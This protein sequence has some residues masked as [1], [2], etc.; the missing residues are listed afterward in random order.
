M[1]KVG[2]ISDT[3]GMLRRAAL[4]AL[5]GCEQIIHAGDV[6]SGEV[7][8]ALEEICPVL[9]VRG[10]MDS[11][12]LP[13]PWTAAVE[14]NGRMIYTLHILGELDLDPVAAGFAAVIHGHTHM[15]EVKQRGGVYYFNPGSAGPRR[16]LKPVSVGLM[17]LEQERVLARI[18]YL[19]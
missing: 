13:L 10:N 12:A 14:V 3:H 15:P 8:A 4:D 5:E 9:A 17:E 11:S 16:G 19:D 2:L 18:V 1:A 6:G 7:I